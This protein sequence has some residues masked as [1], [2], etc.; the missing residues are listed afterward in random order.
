MIRTIAPLTPPSGV[1]LAIQTRRHW[2]R[3]LG[4]TPLL[5][6]TLMAIAAES[7][8]FLTFDSLQQLV[9][10]PTNSVPV[11]LLPPES[12]G[13][14]NQIPSLP[15]G[16]QTPDAARSRI[17]TGAASIPGWVWFPS[18]RPPLAVY[19]DSND[20]YGNSAVHP[21]P[22][23][24]TTPL[25]GWVQQAKYA[26]SDVGLNYS[27]AQTLTVA[28][29]SGA[30]RGDNLLGFYTFDWAFKWTVFDQ[31][32]AGTAG[33][34]SA[35]IEAKASLNDAAKTQSAQTNIESLSNPTAILNRHEGFR[36]PELAWQESFR[37]GE[38]VVLAGVINQSNYL[39]VN[40]YAN[41]GRGQFLNSGLINSQVLPL[42]GYNFGLNLQ[43]QPGSEWYA[44]A[45]Y[46][47]GNASAGQTPWTQF[48]WE[49]W[50][51]VGEFGYTPS[52]AFGLGP[53]VYRIQPFVAQTE[54]PVQ[55]GLGFNFQQ[56]LG[57]TIPLG[58][59]GRFGVG[60][61]DVVS[62]AGA[63]VG[64]GFVIQAPLKHMGLIDGQPYDAAG[65]GLIW[66]HPPDNAEST[67]ARDETAL[68]LVYVFHL[69]PTT[70]VQP[71]LQVVW[72]PSHSSSDQTAL[73]FQLQVDFKW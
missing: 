34:L 5:V 43:W 12:M 48:S 58:W 7:D 52:D 18:R 10:L 60:G 20:A 42:P 63:Q 19:L 67:P 44:T 55:G 6:P 35:Q 13:I 46:T 32:E 28:G 40:A 11:N 15:R 53:G 17:E 2:D 51:L 50:S 8:P 3:W 27:L 72:N 41:S 9:P 59:Y 21:G 64:T 49:A 24:H 25:D 71:D 1:G 57:K 68:E 47:V 66:S 29:L 33:W 62:G 38:V 26:L 45:G 73:V 39:D 61:A 70:R 30:T 23:I 69:T 56:Q 16:I 22:L 54:G 14:Q 65:I 36:I 31:S 37:N 4:W